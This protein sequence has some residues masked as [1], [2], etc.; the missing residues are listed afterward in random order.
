LIVA[1]PKL[2]CEQEPDTHFI[3]SNIG[4]AILGAALSRAADQSYTDYVQEHIYAP[5]GMRHTRFEPDDQMIPNLARG[6]VLHDGRIDPEKPAE[7][8]RKGRG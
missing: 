5:L 1:L 7:E 6:Y 8:L 2:K 3:Y 4:Y